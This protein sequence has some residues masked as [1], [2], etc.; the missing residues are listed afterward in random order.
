MTYILH[1]HR[2]SGSLAV[3]MALAEIGARYEVRDVDLE[4]AAQRHEGYTSI[5][6]Q[7]KVPALITPSGETLT[8]SVAILLTLS[9]RH[10]E[11]ELLPKDTTDRAQ[12]VR[13]LMFMATEI[14]PVVEI[15]DYPERFSPTKETVAGVRDI[16]RSIWRKRWLLVE[17][18]IAGTPY[19]LRSGFCLADIYVAV[20]SRWAQQNMW[21]IDNLPK[22]EMLTAK[23]A[24]RP[25]IAPVWSRHQPEVTPNRFC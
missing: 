20:V 1:G 6:P 14:Y 16:A 21:R 10:P 7:Q 8:E 2:R 12:A 19:F 24:A 18:E 23:V 3:E 25:A 9:E 11:A 4:A 15:N 13:W 22:V 17:H 5:N